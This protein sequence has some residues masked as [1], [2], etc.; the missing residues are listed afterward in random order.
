[1][2]I[3]EAAMPLLVASSC[4]TRVTMSSSILNKDQCDT[5]RYR[6]M[7]GDYVLTLMASW[8]TVLSCKSASITHAL[9]VSS[10]DRTSYTINE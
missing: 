3:A 1:M 7:E 5:S 8:V 10:I 4:F 9:V 2:A 6:E